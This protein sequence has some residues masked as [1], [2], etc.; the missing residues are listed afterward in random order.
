MRIAAKS[1]VGLNT[2]LYGKTHTVETKNRIAFTKHIPVKVTDIETNSARIYEN[3]LDA[4][5]HLGIGEST[6]RRYKK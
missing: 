4:A 5:K 1:C 2:S 3:N 6:L